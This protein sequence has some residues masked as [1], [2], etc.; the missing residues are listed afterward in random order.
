MDE[1]H[2]EFQLLQGRL[3][4]LAPRMT[5]RAIDA[6]ERT[7]V[8]VNSIS[9]EVPTW[10][11][12]LFPA[13][14]ERFL[15]LVLILLR[16]PRTHVIYVTSQPVLPRVIDYWFHIVPQLDRDEARRRLTL[17]SLCD[18]SP[19]PLTQKMLERPRLLERIRSRIVAP[20]RSFVIPFVVSPL[21]RELAVRLGIPVYGPD[22]ELAHF[23][24]KTG[25]RNIFAR[26]DVPH[27]V[28]VDGV[29]GLPDVVSAI[30]SIRAQRPDC[31][32]A[33]IKLDDGVSGL[34]N[35]LIT[36]GAGG[37]ASARALAL[38]DPRISA[39]EFY[40]LVRERGAIVEER[41]SG[42]DFRSPSAQLRVRPD[43][44]LEVLAT[45]DQVLGGPHG[46]TY[47]GCR[48]PADAEYAAMVGREARKAGELLRDEG[49]IGRFAIDFVAVR[50]GSGW[51]TYA[52]EIN[53]RNGGTTHPL[54]TLQALTEGSYDVDAG[55]FL[56]HS[57]VPKHYV[58]TDDLEGEGYQSLTPDDLLDI[59]AAEQ[60]GWDDE[61]QRGVT[62]HM[63]SAL[64]VAG[65][66]GL[67]AIGD[68]LEDASEVYRRVV[69]VVDEAARTDGA[70]ARPVA[71]TAAP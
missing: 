20:E 15:C 43:G 2:A 58:A 42:T 25:S 27:P 28:G 23:G 63:V 40:E 37:E 45:H 64:A 66:V 4:E 22:P 71:P 24:T 44:E 47:H 13:Y 12:P 55:A 9:L 8:V 67:T 35:G 31:R 39:D 10:I 5:I 29:A 18:S 68:S 61:R 53:L 26:A 46:Q 33:I 41:I 17:V 52:V 65:R 57:G 34:G 49:V 48:L 50:D 54:F 6:E 16:Q 38:E 56:S 3:R 69:D 59:A 19:R 60:L 36:I 51:S 32:Q 30:D 7:I 11:S 70:P 62:F 1:L 14:E 21:E